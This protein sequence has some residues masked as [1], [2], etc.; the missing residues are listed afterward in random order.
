M[1]LKFL[2]KDS[3]SQI[4]LNLT[5]EKCVVSNHLSQVEKR[6]NASK[7][8]ISLVKI[9]LGTWL[10]WFET[11]H[12]SEVKFNE[13]CVALSFSKNFRYIHTYK[14]HTG[15]LV[16]WGQEP[17]LLQ[18]WLNL[19]IP[20]FYF[21]SSAPTSSSWIASN[22]GKNREWKWCYCAKFSSM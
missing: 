1:Y 5:W 17:K 6:N 21:F 4:S 16:L 19:R 22:Y 14:L 12:F 3:A 18:T 7:N 15:I 11:T 13:T 9:I 2:E 10:K 8:I 20:R